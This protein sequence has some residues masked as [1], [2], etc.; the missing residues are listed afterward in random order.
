VNLSSKAPGQQI[1]VKWRSQPIFVVRRTP[2]VLAM[3]QQPPYANNWMEK[4]APEYLDDNPTICEFAR[5]FSIG[6]AVQLFH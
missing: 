3:L 6:S 4:P 1:V 5:K 2:A